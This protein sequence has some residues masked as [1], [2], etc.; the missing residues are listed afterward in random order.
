ML[1]YTFSKSHQ[2]SRCRWMSPRQSHVLRSSW[3]FSQSSGTYSNDCDGVYFKNR[4]GRCV[5]LNECYGNDYRAMVI[6]LIPIQDTFANVIMETSEMRFSARLW[7]VSKFFEVRDYVPSDPT[8]KSLF[9]FWKTQ[10]WTNAKCAKLKIHL[11]SLLH[12]IFWE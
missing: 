10:V 2:N 12:R 7:I 3:T 6:A 4:C 1:S 9:Q 5:N 8:R 11:V